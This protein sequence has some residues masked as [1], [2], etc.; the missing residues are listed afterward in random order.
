MYIALRLSE[1]SEPQVAEGETN[2]TSAGNSVASRHSTRSIRNID[3][4]G[5]AREF[6]TR[7]NFLKPISVSPGPALARV[8]QKRA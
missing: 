6:G 1:R 3:S 4:N 5:G 7:R 8:R 2:R